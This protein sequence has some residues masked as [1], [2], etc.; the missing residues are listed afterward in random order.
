MQNF[1]LVVVSHLSQFDGKKFKPYYLDGIDNIGVFGDEPFELQF[2]NHTGQRVQ[3]RLSLDGTDV[4]TGKQA[5]TNTST[6]GMW[7]VEAYGTLSLKA[8]VETTERG[9]SFVFSKES[10]SV[11]LH[12]HGDMSNKGIIAAAVFTEGYVTPP[13]RFDYQGPYF[14][15]GGNYGSYTSGNGSYG[16]GSYTKGRRSAMDRSVTKSCSIGDKSLESFTADS[17]MLD[18]APAVGAG[19]EVMQKIGTA[20]GLI[21]PRLDRII[22][23]R[24]MWWDNLEEKLAKN[25][26]ARPSDNHPSGFPGDRERPM[27]NLGSTPTIG[28]NRPAPRVEIHRFA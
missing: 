8:W 23:M 16:G 5:H 10:N 1:E 26:Y 28:S 27:A 15:L 20:A 12:T 4:A 2:R 17:D 14:Q 25:G 6:D 18:A 9:R 22:R 13:S 7:I 24:Y 19:V 21:Q 11:A 3:T